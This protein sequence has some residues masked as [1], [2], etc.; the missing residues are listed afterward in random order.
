MNKI[1]FRISQLSL[2]SICG[3]TFAFFALTANAQSLN[4]KAG[5]NLSKMESFSGSEKLTTNY[6]ENDEYS[7]YEEKYKMLPGFHIGTSFEFNIGK[8]FSIEP[9]I[10]FSTKGMK[11]TRISESDYVSSGY[12]YSYRNSQTSVVR[13]NNIDVPVLFHGILPIGEV[14]LYV[15]LGGYI[16][17]GLTGKQIYSGE[18]D[19]TYNGESYSYNEKDEESINYGPSEDMS[20][21][22]FGA[23][24][25][26]G[27]QFKGFFLEANYN[28]GFANLIAK[29]YSDE[30]YRTNNRVLGITFGYKINFKKDDV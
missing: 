12:N 11:Y 6:S 24:G 10:Q 19:E 21:L 30:G 29:D 26:I 18:G 17:I 23:V 5:L 20:R 22:D 16:G 3:I 28:Y 8:Y 14:K 4:F 2:K 25:G 1:T 13:T 27:V 15:T 7:S 9:G